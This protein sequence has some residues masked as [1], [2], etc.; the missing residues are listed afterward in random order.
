MNFFPQSNAAYYVIR[1]L[2]DRKNDKRGVDKYDFKF[3]A[4]SYATT[5]TVELKIFNQCGDNILKFEENSSFKSR[6][7]RYKLM[8]RLFLTFMLHTNLIS[9]FLFNKVTLKYNLN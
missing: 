9:T 1:S 2:F 5:L 7:E 4:T 6:S 8:S 3:N